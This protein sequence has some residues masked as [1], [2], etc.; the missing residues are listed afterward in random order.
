[1]DDLKVPSS[2]NWQTTKEVNIAVVMPF[3]I[4]YS[5]FR[6]RIDIMTAPSDEGGVVLSSGSVE[7]TGHYSANL[8]IPS[9]LNRLFVRSDVGASYIELSQTKSSS[10]VLDGLINFGEGYDTLPPAD[11]TLLSLKNSPTVNRV[12]GIPIIKQTLAQNLIQ[13]GT[14]DVN[15]FGSFYDWSSPMTVDG[16]WYYTSTFTNC[17]GQYNDNGNNVLRVKP[18]T[19]IY[20]SGGVAQLVKAK[21]GDLITFSADFKLVGSANGNNHAWLYIIPRSANGTS[22]NYYNYHIYPIAGNS[23]WTRYTIA[24]T[25][26]A[27]TTDVQILLWQWI[28]NGYYYWDNVVVTGPS[29]DSDGDGVIDESDEYPNDP[30]RAFNVYYPNQNDFSTLAFE[31]NWPGKGDY[32]F[33]DLVVDYQYKQVANGNNALVELFGKFS[34]RAIG[35]SFTNGFGFQMELNSDK[36][37]SVTGISQTESYV[38]LGTNNAEAGQ[39]KGTI[40]ISDN[41]FTQLP[42]TGGGIGVN[43]TPGLPYVTPVMMDIK[44]SLNQPV[45]L[46]QA[47]VPPYNPFLIVNRQRGREIHMPNKPPTNLADISLFGTGDDN[48]IPEIN[49]YYKTINNLPWALNIPYKFEYPIEKAQIVQ[50][51]LHFAEWAQTGGNQY[52]SWYL[53][54]SGYRNDNLI[55][56]EPER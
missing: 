39:N 23:P 53:N 17:V 40:I 47:G 3:T 22:L 2:F 7:S 35:A 24:A 36:I 45:P 32:D 26:P 29:P 49:Q 44:V 20:R 21:P 10:A 30:L 4:D 8:I 18:P 15:S 6:S 48:S 13:N 14:F 46:V 9:S 42:Q 11:T 34:I 28:Y 50:A 56:T 25:M 43:T 12:R 38:T 33:N 54:T 41:V 52:P 1:M 37:S 5:R 27:G 19:S 16:K 31:D 55:Y 51:Y